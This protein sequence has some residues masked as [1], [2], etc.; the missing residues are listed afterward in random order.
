MRCQEKN[1]DRF[2]GKEKQDSSKYHA[3]VPLD[4]AILFTLQFLER[5]NFFSSEPSRQLTA[6]NFILINIHKTGQD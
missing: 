2:E 5:D 1:P 6:V 3:Q 4:R